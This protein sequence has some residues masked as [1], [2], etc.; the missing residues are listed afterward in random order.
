MKPRRRRVAGKGIKKSADKVLREAV[1]KARV[2]I[3]PLQ[4]I[5]SAAQ[6]A[7]SAARNVV[8]REQHQKGLQRIIS[9]P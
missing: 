8:R 3:R 5:N 7:L 6:M 4:Y 9:V 2:A 1:R